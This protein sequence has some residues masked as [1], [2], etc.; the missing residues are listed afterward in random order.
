MADR[1]FDTFRDQ[2]A[3]SFP[4]LDSLLEGGEGGLENWWEAAK[5]LITEQL[6][7]A[8]NILDQLD[9]V[10]LYQSNAATPSRDEIP[11]IPF[12]FH[13]LA[14]ATTMT[15]AEFVAFQTGQAKGLRD[16]I[17]AAAAPPTSLLDVAAGATQWT[18]RS[19]ETTSE[20]QSLM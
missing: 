20:L 6:P 1:S 7:A 18:D 13:I 3:A 11:F 17:P 19:E 16:A 9:F 8:K 10:G 5:D 2:M 14:A 12:R 4:S 15:R